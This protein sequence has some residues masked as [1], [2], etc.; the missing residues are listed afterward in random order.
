MRQFGNLVDFSE[1]PG[2][3][4]G[5]PPIVGQNTREI[6]EWLGYRDDEMIALK[7]QRAVYWPDDDYSW[8]I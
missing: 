2:R 3:I 5:P 8:S 1:T 6:L 4:G 7:E